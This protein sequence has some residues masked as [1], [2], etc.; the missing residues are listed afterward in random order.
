MRILEII[1]L[2]STGNC[3]GRDLLRGILR[4]AASSQRWRI[5][6]CDFA[7]NGAPKALDLLMREHID[8]IITSELENADISNI[9]EHSQIP[10]AVIGTRENAL[11][12]RQEN[13]TTI[14]SDEVSIGALG[15]QAL[16][17]FGNFNS[18]AFVN[19]RNETYRYLS[20]LRMNGFV[21][22][23]QKSRITPHVYHTAIPEKESDESELQ[24]WI[25]A[26]PKPTAILAANDNR[27]E[28]VIRASIHAGL[29][30]PTQVSVLGIDDDEFKCLSVSPTISSINL[31]AEAQGYTAAKHLNKMLR[32]H[33]VHVM[34]STHFAGNIKI[35]QRGSTRT[36]TPGKVLVSRAKEFIAKNANTALKISDV[37]AFSHVSQRLLFLR[38]KE[39]SDKSIQETINAERIK[40]FCKRLQTDRGK[41]QDIA[42]LCGFK[43]MATLRA[44]FF[45][46]TGMTI[47]GWRKHKEQN[48]QPIDDRCKPTPQR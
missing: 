5:R 11:P 43:N 30:I 41:I 14:A 27:A 10:L 31:N 1:I 40:Y 46:H 16:L 9:L 33:H 36:L 44:L 47:R 25:R 3:S 23:L 35:V 6:I 12:T 29:N 18:V 42:T 24:E 21:R 20:S 4:F 28:D 39:F 7:D 15:A 38:F 17:R 34:R 32:C 22:Q 2:V 19:I 37:V 26:L 45:E 48:G 8:G 13:M